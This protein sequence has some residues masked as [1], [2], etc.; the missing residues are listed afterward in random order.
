MVQFTCQFCDIL[1]AK[2]KDGRGQRRVS[3]S[4]AEHLDEVA[5]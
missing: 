2:V 5:R 4:F 3:P 1:D